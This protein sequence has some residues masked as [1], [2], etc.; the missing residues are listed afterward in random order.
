MGRAA[1]ANRFRAVAY[2]VAVKLTDIATQT[3]ALAQVM[4]A[5]AI[6]VFAW[7]MMDR[8][9]PFTLLSVSPAAAKPGE[10]VTIKAKVRRDLDRQC[11]AEFSRYMFALTPGPDL[12]GPIETRFVLGTSI[13]PHSMIAMMEKTWPMGLV[14][15]ERV[16]ETVLAGPAKITADISYVCNKGHRLW[17]ITVHMEMPFTVLP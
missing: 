14:I 12:G 6:L 7:G 9:P 16:P 11:D 17:P 10:M 5:T 1:Q 3:V 15:S 2:S 13:A 8:E 4:I